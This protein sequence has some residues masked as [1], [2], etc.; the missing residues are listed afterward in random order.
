[1]ATITHT[2]KMHPAIKDT[3]IGKLFHMGLTN[4]KIGEITGVGGSAVC[5]WRNGQQAP[6]GRRFMLA[7]KYLDELQTP[8]PAPAPTRTVVPPTTSK[9]T[10][11]NAPPAKPSTD[12]MVLV[13]VPAGRMDAFRKL[14][15]FG[16]FDF[17]TDEG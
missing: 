13:N 11:R 12:H 5:K 4:D 16:G 9:L 1:M 7:Q 6:S 10:I 8:E 15:A 3:A 2:D 14:M 17:L